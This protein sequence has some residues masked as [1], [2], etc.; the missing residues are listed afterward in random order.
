MSLI[1]ITAISENKMTS[2]LI[3]PHFHSI[4]PVNNLVYLLPQ[5]GNYFNEKKRT[6]CYLDGFL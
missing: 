5:F 3:S 1:H 2:A 6:I 4:A